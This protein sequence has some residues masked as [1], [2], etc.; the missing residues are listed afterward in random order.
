MA[1]STAYLEALY[2]IWWAG[3]AAVPINAKLHGREAAWMVEDAGAKLVFC[4]EKSSQGPVWSFVW[5]CT[6]C[7]DRQRGL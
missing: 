7:H 1:N 5:R 2:G 6:D 4:D 3:A